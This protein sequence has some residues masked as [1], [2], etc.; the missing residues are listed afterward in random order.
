MPAI[1]PT[2]AAQSAELFHK[3]TLPFK[4]IIVSKSAATV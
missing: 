3:S 2:G 1:P 4:A